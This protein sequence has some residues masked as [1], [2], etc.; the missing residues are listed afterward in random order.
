MLETKKE[1][2]VEVQA[3]NAEVKAVKKDT[4]KKDSKGKVIK[5]KVTKSKSKK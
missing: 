5:K 4:P 2:K 3:A 1:V